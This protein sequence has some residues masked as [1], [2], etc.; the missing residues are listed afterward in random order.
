MDFVEIPEQEP[1]EKERVKVEERFIVNYVFDFLGKYVVPE[2]LGRHLRHSDN[3]HVQSRSG[4]DK[5][6]G[7]VQ[8]RLLPVPSANLTCSLYRDHSW[9]QF[10]CLMGTSIWVFVN[11]FFMTVGQHNFF[12]YG[13]PQGPEETFWD[14][15]FMT[16][17]PGG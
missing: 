2:R 1:T 12:G 9:L 5:G 16:R 14:G 6:A 3:L 15:F 17:R 10:S 11:N 4:T 7:G 13:P 8:R